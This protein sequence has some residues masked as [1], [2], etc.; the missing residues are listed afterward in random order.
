VIVEVVVV[1]TLMALYCCWDYP[2]K[3]PERDG[4]QGEVL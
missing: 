4:A 2:L 1:G 3:R